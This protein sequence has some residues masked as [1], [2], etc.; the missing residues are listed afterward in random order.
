MFRSRFVWL[1]VGLLSLSL[2]GCPNRTGP[3]FGR[4]PTI[5]SD[6]QQAE[7]DLAA[8]RKL[9]A[10]GDHN[11]AAKAFRR[12]IDRYPKDAL[13]PVAQLGLARIL[14]A[15]GRTAEAK[16]LL[17]RVAQHPDNAL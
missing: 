3:D 6:N 11:G 9:D 17:D 1:L 2:A 5:T 4:L 14:L 10:D 7:S 13:V 16:T 15:K 8:A 12:F